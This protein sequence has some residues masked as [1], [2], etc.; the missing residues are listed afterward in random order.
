MGSPRSTRWRGYSPRTEVGEFLGQQFDARTLVRRPEGGF[1]SP[2]G[3]L[4]WLD[5]PPATTARQAR[6]RNTP[7]PTAHACYVPLSNTRHGV[8]ELHF[9]LT[10]HSQP[11]GGLVWRFLCPGCGK[12]RLA[13]YWHA[14][15][16][17]RCRECES[18]VYASQRATRRGRANLR[19]EKLVKQV[20][21]WWNDPRVFPERPS[22]AH[23]RRYERLKEAWR[24]ARWE[25]LNRAGREALFGPS[26]R[27]V[28]Y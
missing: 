15:V 1:V 6:R 16:I 18:I 9:W 25:S 4:T 20:V 28:E 14:F 24:E 17:P 2:G 21:P 8:P 10:A 5:P 19:M 7:T 23:R 3:T 12:R 13:L 11:G 26:L 22:G 27:H